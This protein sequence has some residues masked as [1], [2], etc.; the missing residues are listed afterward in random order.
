MDKREKTPSALQ[1]TVRFVNIEGTVHV[2][3][4]DKEVSVE[5]YRKKIMDDPVIDEMG[6]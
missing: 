1:D 3:D 5:A 2:I 6:E 4:L